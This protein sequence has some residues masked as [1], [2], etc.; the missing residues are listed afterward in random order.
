MPLKSQF[1]IMDKNVE[2]LARGLLEEA[3]HATLIPLI[4]DTL[5]GLPKTSQATP[6]PRIAPVSISAKKR[7]ATESR[8]QKFGHIMT[9]AARKAG[10]DNL[11]FCRLLDKEDVPTPWPEFKKWKGAYM[12][13]D[14]N[15]DFAKRG[16]IRNIKHRALKV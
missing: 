8:D 1:E 12:Y 5:K 2:N 16:A 7:A 6:Q 10:K 11:K 9:R 14:A 15:G 4:G 13:S 3:A